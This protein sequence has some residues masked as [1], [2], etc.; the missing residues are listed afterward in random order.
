MIV[1]KL[2]ASQIIRN[3]AS[4]DKDAAFLTFLIEMS[5]E[6][7]NDVAALLSVSLLINFHFFFMAENSSHLN[8]LEGEFIVELFDVSVWLA[9]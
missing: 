8:L 3:P 7:S 2:G 9:P 5:V 4:V 1:V 6:R